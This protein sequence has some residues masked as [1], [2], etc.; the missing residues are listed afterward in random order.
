MSRA[1]NLS[2]TAAEVTAICAGLGVSTTA[3]EALL[4]TGTRVVCRTSEG[5]VTLRNK[6]RGKI[7]EGTVTRAPRT[8][9]P[10]LMS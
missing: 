8:I 9:A 3:I 4:P 5:M 7:I 6:M 1:M 10:S 2:A